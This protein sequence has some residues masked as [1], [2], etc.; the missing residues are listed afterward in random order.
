MA[1]TKIAVH[2]LTDLKNTTDDALPNYLTSLSFKQS[3]ILTDVRLALGYV[4]VAIAAATCYF[5]YTLGFEKTKTYT[6]WAVIAYFVI[7]G[8]FTYWIWGVEGGKVFV[9]ELK[10]TKL[11]LSSNV[12]KHIPIYHL[13]A[14]YAV[15]S[16]GSSEKEGE[17][18]WQTIQLSAP[19]TRWF[20]SDGSFVP[21]PF[22]EWLASEIPV[23]GKA[24]PGNVVQSDGQRKIVIDSG[25]ISATEEVSGGAGGK[26]RSERPRKSTKKAQ[27][28]R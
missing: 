6:L 26:R 18:L 20:S 3:N 10:G 9:G 23:V 16:S 25:D 17:P 11:I 12:T 14:R 24:D 19:F 8:A 21:K 15:P 13:T 7:N 22:Q 4:A 28:L 2:S 1:D 27:E 5:D